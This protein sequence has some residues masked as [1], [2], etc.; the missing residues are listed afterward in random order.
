MEKGEM[1]YE[2]KKQYLLALNEI[3]V[4]MMFEKNAPNVFYTKNDIEALLAMYLFERYNPHND[5][6]RPFV[7]NCFGDNGDIA[8]AA[9]LTDVNYIV[10]EKEQDKY[11]KLESFFDGF[12]NSC[13][14][15]VQY[16]TNENLT[17]FCANKNCK[18]YFD[19]ICAF[20]TE[21]NKKPN[22]YFN[23]DS[24]WYWE[25]VS[26]KA[27]DALKAGGIFLYVTCNNYAAEW[28]HR[29]S[30]MALI[31]TNPFLLKDYLT[32]F[33]Y[34]NMNFGTDSYVT[35][36]VCAYQKPLK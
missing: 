1:T 29:K 4:K 12:G 10:S 7:F 25:C 35:Y 22:N 14:Y 26:K 34:N 6:T 24:T 2:D 3:D 17:K 11:E 5:G 28:I 27:Y 30:M 33:V 8:D 23:P 13:D 20:V 15:G 21:N 9:V 16:V 31:E 18:N 36:V 19:I 32:Y